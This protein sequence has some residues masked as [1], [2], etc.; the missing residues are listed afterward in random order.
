MNYVNLFKKGNWLSKSNSM[1]SNPQKL[2][3]MMSK[4]PSYLRKSGLQTVKDQL[5]L[6]GNYLSDVI[7][8][9]YKDYSV[10]SLTLA[11][12]AVLYVVSPLDI[13]PDFIP[14]GLIDD[15]AIISWAYTKLSDEL[16]KYKENY[17][18]RHTS[19]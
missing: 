6:V 17:V 15:V 4:L 16:K 13:I 18:F 19:C 2:K 8:G 12:A 14:A 11:V 5:T 10:T 1:L 3:S 9:R 7:H